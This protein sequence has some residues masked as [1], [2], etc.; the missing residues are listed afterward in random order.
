M[1]IRRA[2]IPIDRVIVWSHVLPTSALPDWF[3]RAIEAL[4]AGDADG[5]IAIYA[6][7]A[8][9]EFPFA[10]RCATAGWC[11]FAIT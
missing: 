5:W 9:H 1:T 3:A 4:Q 7:D 2:V 6:P 11:T 8:V 10:S